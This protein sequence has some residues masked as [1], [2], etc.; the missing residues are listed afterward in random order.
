MCVCF[1]VRNCKPEKGVDYSLC[2]GWATLIPLKWNPQA[3]GGGGGRARR[4]SSSL[5]HHCRLCLHLL[6]APLSSSGS[7]ELLPHLHGG[8]CLWVPQSDRVPAA[9]PPHVSTSSRGFQNHCLLLSFSCE[10]PERGQYLQVQGGRGWLEQ[11]KPSAGPGH[12]WVP[13]SA[14]ALPP[15]L[16]QA[17]PPVPGPCHAHVPWVHTLSH[18]PWCRG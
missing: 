15:C 7:G 12:M 17:P 13:G 4:A 1:L 14:V 6:G 11:T 10:A 9:P 5:L 16:P 2:R 3:G 8:L 18:V